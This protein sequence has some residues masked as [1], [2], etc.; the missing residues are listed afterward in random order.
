MVTDRASPSKGIARSA[1]AKMQGTLSGKVGLE[2]LHLITEDTATLK[3]NILCMGGGKRDGQKLHTGLL[4]RPARL[5]IV[6]TFAG[7][8]HIAP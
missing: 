3:V 6:A 1:K 5:V 7:S 8:D 2:K 4:W